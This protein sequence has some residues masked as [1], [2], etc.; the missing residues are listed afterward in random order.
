MLFATR[1]R[2]LTKITYIII[3]GF[4]CLFAANNLKNNVCLYICL[5]E[6]FI[7]TYWHIPI[8]HH[9]SQSNVW[10]DLSQ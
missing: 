1:I 7:K 5:E 3:L 10:A 2:I 6:I 9:S 8:L 4:V